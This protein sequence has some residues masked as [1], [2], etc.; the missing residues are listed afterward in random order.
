[1]KLYLIEGSG[2]SVCLIRAESLEE[3][4][5][6]VRM[7]RLDPYFGEVFGHEHESLYLKEVPQEGPAELIFFTAE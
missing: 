2:Y 6:I 1:M 3:A 7:K 5:K 4:Q